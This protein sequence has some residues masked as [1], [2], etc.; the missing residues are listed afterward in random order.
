MMDPV[1]ERGVLLGHVWQE[2]RSGRWYGRAVGQEQPMGPFNDRDAAV[3]AVRN[4]VR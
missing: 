3:T 1:M 2:R 4:H